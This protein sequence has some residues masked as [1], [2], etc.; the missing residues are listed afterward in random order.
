MTLYEKP[1]TNPVA[2]ARNRLTRQLRDEV[3]S[4]HEVRAAYDDFQSALFDLAGEG[5]DVYK[6]L[7]QMTIGLATSVGIRQDDES[8]Q[9]FSRLTVQYRGKALSD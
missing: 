4:G 9:Y 8:V 5:P 3:Y 1:G 7:V 6:E 2:I